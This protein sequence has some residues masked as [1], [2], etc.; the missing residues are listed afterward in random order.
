[1]AKVDRFE[2]L[3]SWQEARKLVKIVYEL[4]SEGPIA[5]D[6]DM[7]SQMRRAAISTMNNIAEGFGRFSTKEF[8]RF[9]EISSSSACEV[10]S[11]SY[12]AI[13]LEYFTKDKVK[14]IQD[15]ADDVK[16]LD[17]GFIRYLKNRQ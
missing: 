5:K 4:T 15:K 9:L 3:H 2:D 8:I 1:M 12:A 14:R 11:L 6:F 7:R 16:A 10:K 17:L 13:D